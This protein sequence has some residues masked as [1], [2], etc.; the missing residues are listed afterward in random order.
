VGD[1]KVLF[2]EG[3]EAAGS[4]KIRATLWALSNNRLIR[5]DRAKILLYCWMAESTGRRVNE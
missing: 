1:E 2:D 5:D 3:K 4:T